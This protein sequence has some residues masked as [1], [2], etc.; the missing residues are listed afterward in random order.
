MTSNV[1]SQWI[2]DLSIPDEEKKNRDDGMPC[3]PTFKPEFLN[4]ID[5]MIIFRALT[6]EDIDRIVDIQI[7]L[8]HKRLKERKMTLELTEKTKNYIAKTATARLR[9]QT[10]EKGPSENY[11][12]SIWPWKF[13]KGISLKEITSWLMLQRRRHSFQKDK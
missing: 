1:G 9:R 2:Q 3:E 13:W 10:A 6:L 8:I 11:P 7:G 12:G 4:R 5:D